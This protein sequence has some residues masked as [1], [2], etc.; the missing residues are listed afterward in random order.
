MAKQPV[1]SAPRRWTARDA[2]HRQRA[3]WDA[4]FGHEPDHMGPRPSPMA[5]YALGHLPPDGRGLRLVELGCGTGRDLVEFVRRGYT[6]AA[7]DVSLAAVRA[8]RMR[9]IAVPRPHRVPRPIIDHGEAVEFLATQSDASADF[10]YSNLFLTMGTPDRHLNT[11]FREVARILRPG[12]LHLFSVRSTE[13]GWF[14]RGRELAPNVF[15]LAPDGP[16]VR[17]YDDPDLRRRT[18]TAFERIAQRTGREG[19][20]RFGRIVL[21]TVDRRRGATGTDARVHIPERSTPAR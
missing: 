9:S 15:D 11:L 13:D 7:I 10:V 4:A 6:V 16:P 21:Y 18:R 2:R 1:Q 8:T 5:R 12:G 3:F 20:G 17:F 14:G 19:S